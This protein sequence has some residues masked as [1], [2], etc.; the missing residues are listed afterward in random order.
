[1]NPKAIISYDDTLNDHDALALGRV[2]AAVGAELELAYVRHTTQSDR[3]REEL[4][5]NQAEALLE[6]GARWLD[7]L[8]VPRRVVLSASTGEGLAWLAADENADIV[9]FG[10][11]YRTPAG[12]VD[13]GTSARRLLEGGTA[14]VAIAP[15]NYRG[16]RETTIRTIG[17]LDGD[18]AAR[19]T[20]N[21]IADQ[22]G[23]VVVSAPA[24]KIDLLIVASRAEAQEGRVMVSAQAWR[25]IEDATG[26]V[27]VVPRGKPVRF[28]V[29][30]TAAH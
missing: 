26:P 12:H 10:S 2:L 22:L 1:M 16:Q 18:P 15:A 13:P 3:S 23:A 21:E 28:A 29:P 8:D 27:L 17:V 20:A 19:T 7:N 30:A 25:A 5:Q 11:D 14:A 9:V 6:R 4:D 24:A